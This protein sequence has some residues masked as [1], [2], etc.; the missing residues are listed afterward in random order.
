MRGKMAYTDNERIRHEG[1]DSR[2]L[3]TCFVKRLPLMLTLAVT[4][5]VIGS[6]LN[7]LLAF[8]DLAS[9]SYVS[10]TE[11]YIDFADGR[12]EAK[13]YYNDFTWNDVVATDL[14]LGNAMN[15]LGAGYERDA[16][17]SMITADILSD[18]RYLTITVEGEDAETVDKVSKALKV[19]LEHFGT[20]MDEF[21]SIY[22]IEDLGIKKEQ[23]QFFVWRAALL[24]AA[25]LLCAGAFA[26]VFRFCL[27]D[28]IYTKEDIRK[29]FG[30]PAY[31]LLYSDKNNA[32]GRQEKML[33]EA[34]S[35]T[36]GAEKKL[37]FADA[38][39]NRIAGEF[40]KKLS[41]LNI[42]DDKTCVETLDKKDG[43]RGQ[44]V[45][46]AIPFGVPCRQ[47]VADEI[48]QL[49]MLGYNV[50]GAVLAEA[51]KGWTRLY[52]GR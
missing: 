24:G 13:D 23:A 9:P 22:Q 5:A 28:C 39:D 37:V 16:V 8:I 26:L 35:A 47:R 1:I 10:E 4:G 38:F 29:Y 20:L 36:F 12:L 45:I 7:L 17:K 31:G 3:F 15:L 34:L 11:Y 52:F 49:G 48:N 40:V 43:L 19:S 18:V 2:A 25:A 27:G 46:I 21:D 50:G 30:I 41:G 51:D 6:G 33:A 42:L 32:D 44:E 14:I